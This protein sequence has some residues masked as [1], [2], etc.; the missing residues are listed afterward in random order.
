MSQ[1]E[2]PTW[3]PFNSGDGDSATQHDSMR[4]TCPVAHSDRL[5]WSLFRHEDVMSVLMDPETFSSAASTHLNVPNG[6]DPPEHTEFRR[7]IE[8]FFSAEEMAL[9]APRCRQTAASLL[10]GLP[11]RTPIDFHREISEEYAVRVQCA[12]LGWPEEL[13]EPLRAWMWQNHEATREQDKTA[14]SEAARSFEQLVTG[15]LAQ[16]RYSAGATGDIT[17]RL[18][19]A[20]V[21]GRPLETGEIVSILRNWTAGEVGTIASATSIVAW[22]LADHGAVQE[23]LRQTPA[24]VP[25]AI[26]EILRLRGPLAANRRVATRCANIG[27][28]QIEAGERVTVMWTSANRDEDAFD[29][30]LAFDWHRSQRNNLL[31][32]AGIHVC[33]RCSCEFADGGCARD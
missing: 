7:I 1:E 2:R 19:Q 17:S 33:P 9:F 5:G 14:M 16:H 27:G 24:L 28:Q 21:F 15:L 32:G 25:D 22:F 4:Q 23:R 20:R 3:D 12:F 29:D 8:P 31:Y 11:A 6:M 10:K 13:F 18:L 30:G 26:E